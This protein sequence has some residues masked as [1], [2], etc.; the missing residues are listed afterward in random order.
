MRQDTRT[1]LLRQVEAQRDDMERMVRIAT[2][3]ADDEIE[4]DWEWLRDNGA[5]I[6]EQADDD[7]MIEAGQNMIDESLLESYGVYHGRPDDLRY[8]GCVVVVHLGGPHVELQT[9]TRT[10]HGY[11]AGNTVV[12]SASRDVCEYFD[13]MFEG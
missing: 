12:L 7:E 5:D 4:G 10:W 11:W 9:E 13:A 3:N 2:G 1:E 6:P 8:Q